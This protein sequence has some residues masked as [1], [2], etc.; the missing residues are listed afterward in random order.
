V[1]STYAGPLSELHDGEAFLV[2]MTRMPYLAQTLQAI[3]LM[4]SFDPRIS[5]S[6]HVCACVCAHVRVCMHLCLSEPML[7]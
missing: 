1:L 6:D 4:R 3:K 5:V 2:E 7:I